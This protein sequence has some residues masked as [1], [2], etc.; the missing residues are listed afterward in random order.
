MD[1]RT[2]KIYDL[3]DEM[4]KNCETDRP[5]TPL[6]PKEYQ[7]MLGH[8]AEDR[9]IELALVRFMAERMKLGAPVTLAVKN[10]FRCGYWAALGNQK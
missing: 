10:A 4:A 8:K 6:S 9:P 2:G 5:L 1:T 7:A 3:N